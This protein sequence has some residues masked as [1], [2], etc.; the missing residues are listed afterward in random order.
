MLEDDE[1]AFPA[2]Q[3]LPVEQ[4]E[5]VELEVPLEGEERATLD[6][7]D[8]R[9]LCFGG[10]ECSEGGE[11]ERYALEALGL[12]P[13]DRLAHEPLVEAVRRRP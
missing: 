1:A 10:E 12:C 3:E 11:V 4:Q 7:L 9:E 13:T 8:A 6:A 2:G 5:V